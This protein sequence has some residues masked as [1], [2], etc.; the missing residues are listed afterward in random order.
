MSCGRGQ[1][2]RLGVILAAG[3]RAG[4]LRADVAPE[5][6]TVMVLGVF[7]ATAGDDTPERT[8]RLLDLVVDALRPRP[9]PE[10]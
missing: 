4:S 9:E 2:S 8:A 6:A 7:V 10:S 3:A 1:G 5:D